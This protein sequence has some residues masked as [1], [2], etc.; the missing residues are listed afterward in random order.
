ML[1]HYNSKTQINSEL[2][3]NNDVKVC[4]DDDVY[5]IM[6]NIEESSYYNKYHNIPFYLLNLIGRFDI[7][8]NRG[9]HR[10][11]KGV[12]TI[13]NI[14]P[15]IEVRKPDNYDINTFISDIKEK[16]D[17]DTHLYYIKKQKTEDPYYADDRYTIDKI[18]GKRFKGFEHEYSDYIRINF[19]NIFDRIRAIRC[20][21]DNGYELTTS[22][23]N[24]YH[25]VVFT[26][27]KNIKTSESWMRLE[28]YDIINNNKDYEMDNIDL[29]LEL[30][31]K[32]IYE[33][34]N[35][36]EDKTITMAW[37]IE[38][39]P[40]ENK[41][42]D[43]SIPKDIIYNIACSFSYSSCSTNF[44]NIS[45]FVSDELEHPNDDTII[46]LCKTEEDLIKAFSDLLSIYQPDYISGFNCTG[47]DWPYLIGRASRYGLLDYLYRSVNMI[48]DYRYDKEKNKEKYVDTYIVNERFIH[49]KDRKQKIT[50]FNV[51]SFIIMDVQKVLIKKYPKQIKVS[52]NSFLDKLH[53]GSKNDMPVWRMIEILN[54][55]EELNYKDSKISKDSK[56][57]KDNIKDLS[58]ISEYCVVDTKKVKELINKCGVIQEAR[59]LANLSSTLLSDQFRYQDG[60]KVESYIKKMCHQK[61][62]LIGDVE[63]PYKEGTFPGALVLKPKSGRAGPPMN[64][65]EWSDGK[66]IPPDLSDHIKHIIKTEYGDI[67]PYDIYILDEYEDYLYKSLGRPSAGL[68]FASLYPHIIMAWNISPE[69][70]IRPEHVDK[71]KKLGYKINTE[72]YEMNDSKEV[73]NTIS[74]NTIDGKNIIDNKYKSPGMGIIPES[75]HYLYTTRNALKSKYKKYKKQL[76]NM[77]YD[78]KEYNEISSKA[79]L[80]N[81]A[82]LA[83][84]ILMN[85]FYGLMGYKNSFIFI[86][87]LAAMVTSKGRI[88]LKKAKAIAESRGFIVNYGDTD[89]I[90]PQAP[91]SY[92]VD[93]DRLYLSG[94]MSRLEY[95]EKQVDITMNSV[96]NLGH[97]INKELETFTSTIFLKM[98]YEEVLYPVFYIGP[99]MYIGMIHEHKCSFDYK[100][101]NVFIRGIASSKRDASPLMKNIIN[102][103][104]LNI[105]HYDTM[106]DIMTIVL[107]KLKSIK[108]REI[109]YD[110][111]KKNALYKS[112][113][114]KSM[115]TFF[116]H[117]MVERDDIDCPPPKPSQRFN[118]VIV[119]KNNKY[120][121]S[122][123][124]Q[125]LQKRDKIEY[126]SYAK[127]H[128]LEIDVADYVDSEISGA[129]CQYILSYD[130]FKTTND[131]KKFIINKW[132]EYNNELKCQGKL[133][134]KVYRI[135]KQKV[136]KYI[137]FNDNNVDDMIESII[138][139]IYNKYED[140]IIY[141]INSIVK[142]LNHKS[143]KKILQSYKVYK[144][145]Y[146]K[147]I[148]SYNN[149]IKE[150]KLI[151]SKYNNI[152][153]EIIKD[154]VERIRN[155]LDLSI[156]KWEN[157]GLDVSV[158][159]RDD[160]NTIIDNVDEDYKEDVIN[161]NK[162]T[163]QI[164]NNILLVYV[165]KVY[166]ES[167]IQKISHLL[168]PN[169]N[170]IKKKNI[171][172]L[173]NNSKFNEAINNA[174]NY[175]THN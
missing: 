41:F 57:Y 167:I 174:I 47:F 142:K 72:Y 50:L 136:N 91:S 62:I 75:L 44:K 107:D 94:N 63:M 52:L 66:N 161:Y 61:N 139:D 124:K 20:L 81:I 121:I 150:S 125:K 68:D 120:D 97:I 118:Y 34:D 82:Q 37:D 114:V 40:S 25:R 73:C 18:K 2:S 17:S 126:L 122:G 159:D 106:G 16:I 129:M 105:L 104:I 109:K 30:D 24:N 95:C 137:T 59:A 89:S 6:N 116:K 19:Y 42:P 164:Y 151:L 141:I 96:K 146:D 85:T 148:N 135:T 112:D 138:L 155:K 10:S 38:V 166:T 127:K 113:D 14:R 65:D 23:K 154:M 79:S 48:R 86:Q 67:P 29:M 131:A 165:K 60:M 26:K 149:V 171:N 80:A 90:Y 77:E 108:T 7:I 143:K 119:K 156:E 70:F 175:K 46:I 168:Y 15:H 128:N 22:N 78:S 92:F 64:F 28:N 36:L 132:K 130:Q 9:E 99:K 157:G 27:N 56:E 35:L 55:Q 140:Y 49:L 133:L 33:C 163:N 39:R 1:I 158:L 110:D 103:L 12:V 173:K 4:R 102:E 53:L 74:H 58:S 83:R 160:I 51:S 170:N 172:T 31:I 134:K 100:L 123:K 162:I 144:T 88:L 87:M 71:F 32:D 117:R 5:F 115:A 93:I 153:Y 169:T 76:E 147:R 101:S 21:F 145:L 98:C 3:F 45:L 11:C 54:K 152:N 84:K 69:M 43:I 8:N 111:F 13:K